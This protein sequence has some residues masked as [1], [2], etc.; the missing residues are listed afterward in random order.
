MLVK[1]LPSAWPA[2]PRER[3]MRNWTVI[4]GGISEAAERPIVAAAL[5]RSAA[6]EMSISRALAGDAHIALRAKLV[7]E[8]DMAALCALH[9][10]VIVVDLDPR[11]WRGLG[12]PGEFL[13]ARTDPP[14]GLTPPHL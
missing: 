11:N 12:L 3:M 13:A 9:G 14:G 7:E 5:V 8:F 10:D 4:E 6:V 1:L 2:H